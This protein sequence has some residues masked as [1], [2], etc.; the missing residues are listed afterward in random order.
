MY[1]II[2]SKSSRGRSRRP[3]SNSYLGDLDI[4]RIWRCR[5]HGAKKNEVPQTM[6]EM[7]RIRVD[8]GISVYYINSW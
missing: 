5:G 3:I 6:P 7:I 2:G 8:L 1:L 4:N